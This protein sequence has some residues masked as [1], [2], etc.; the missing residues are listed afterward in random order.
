MQADDDRNGVIIFTNIC[1]NKDICTNNN[2]QKRKQKENYGKEL[3][4]QNKNGLQLHIFV[5]ISP[6]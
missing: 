2:K 3:A 5:T 1:R 6:K 4:I